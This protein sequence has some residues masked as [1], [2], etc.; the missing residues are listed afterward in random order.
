[1]SSPIPGIVP[2]LIL[3]PAREWC[4]RAHIHIPF[5]NHLLFHVGL[6]F[7]T[8]RCDVQAYDVL[9]I[10]VTLVGDILKKLKHLSIYLAGFADDRFLGTFC[11]I[12]DIIILPCFMLCCFY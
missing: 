12:F 1:M 11:I 6:G 9:E 2:V 5:R 8:Y 10:L 4:P 3:K 7:L